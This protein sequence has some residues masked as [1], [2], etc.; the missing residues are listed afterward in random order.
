MSPTTRTST[1]DRCRSRCRSA[2]AWR[3][4]ACAAAA[5]LG[6][7]TAG[8]VAP[9]RLQ[10]VTQRPLTV[11][12]AGFGR[13][14]RVRVR[15]LMPGA[16]MVRRVRSTRRGVFTVRFA[17]AA[18]DRCSGYSIVASG[19]SGSVATLRWPVRRGCPPARA[20]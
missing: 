11:R 12:G 16:E 20:R 6:T 18:P 1:R 2:L 17:G 13:H 8:A 15:L 7:A 4:V 9:A 3:A 19:A 10:V 5:L 14:E